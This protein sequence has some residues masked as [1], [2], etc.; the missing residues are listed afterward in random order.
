[1]S[2]E[3]TT[4]SVLG[5]TLNLM[6]AAILAGLVLATVNYFTQER[7]EKNEA[8][9]K[10][11]ALQEALPDAASFAA[12]EGAEGEPESYRG[13]G[14][15]GELVGYVL[16]VITRG[17]EGKIEMMLGVDSSLTIVNFQIVK[18]RETPGLGDRAREEWFRERFR[19]L[20]VGSLEVVKQAQAGKVEA[21]TGAT[22]TSR[23]IADAFNEQVERLERLVQAGAEEPQEDGE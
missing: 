22:I 7:R 11:Q 3:S 5:M 18:Q 16:E 4:D 10:R 9:F 21:I 23:A 6:T 14:P 2:R 12:V 15:D 1:M 20:S 17:Y 13:L 8:E 19:G